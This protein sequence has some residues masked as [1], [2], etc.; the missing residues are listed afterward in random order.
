MTADPGRDG[1]P[2]IRFILISGVILPGRPQKALESATVEQ[3]GHVIPGRIIF[4]TRF[5]DMTADQRIKRIFPIRH[6][7]ETRQ[8]IGADIRFIL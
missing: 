4:N 2:D 7:P 1:F 8:R 3:A 5:R 6:K